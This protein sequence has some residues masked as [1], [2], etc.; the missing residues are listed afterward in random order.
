MEFWGYLVPHVKAMPDLI[1][2]QKLNSRILGK[3]F[4]TFWL[5]SLS[6]SHSKMT[7]MKHWLQMLPNFGETWI[8]IWTLQLGPASGRYM[9]SAPQRRVKYI[10]LFA[11]HSISSSS[12]QTVLFF[13][14]ESSFSQSIVIHLNVCVLEVLMVFLVLARTFC[15]GVLFSCLHSHHLFRKRAKSS[16]SCLLK[17]S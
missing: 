9:L 7:Q 15:W 8:Q 10:L 12:L 1:S 16:Q 13:S 14:K 11:L 3:L 4:W 17:S 5:F 2:S 6:L